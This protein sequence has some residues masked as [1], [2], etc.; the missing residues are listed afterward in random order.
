MKVIYI[1]VQVSSRCLEIIART[2]SNIISIMDNLSN[3]S[4][5]HI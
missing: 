3:I 1:Y 5:H 4:D 2:L